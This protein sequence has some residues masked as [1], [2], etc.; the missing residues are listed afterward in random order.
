MSNIHY[1]ILGQAVVLQVF[2]V[3]KSV[4]IQPTYPI[5]PW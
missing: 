3:M 1:D 5:K 2:V 4:V